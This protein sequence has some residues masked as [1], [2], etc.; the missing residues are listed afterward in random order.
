MVLY[1]C[2]WHCLEYFNFE[3][4]VVSVKNRL[5]MAAD[6][7]DNRGRE[8][9]LIRLTTHTETFKLENPSNEGLAPAQLD[10]FLYDW[11]EL[12]WPKPLPEICKKTDTNLS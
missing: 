3:T 4:N 1:R 10:G 5:I 7:V 8:E 12:V 2:F 9:Y 6:L 11:A